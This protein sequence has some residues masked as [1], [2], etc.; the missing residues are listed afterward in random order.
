MAHDKVSRLYHRDFSA[1]DLSVVHEKLISKLNLKKKIKGSISH[2]AFNSLNDYHAK[3]IQYA[4][5]SAVKYYAEGRKAGWIK[6]FFSPVFNSLKSY[7]LHLGF[8]EGKEGISI[9][10][11]IAHYTW[12]KYDQL[13]KMNKETETALVTGEK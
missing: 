9:A 1:W 13:H 12:L 11:T 3:A 7:I 5:M 8:L 2:Y 4:E 10:K 6:R